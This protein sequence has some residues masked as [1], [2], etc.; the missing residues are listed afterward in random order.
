MR[1]IAD[2]IE[3]FIISE[4]FGDDTDSINVK[5]SQ[6][7]EKLSCAPSQITYTLTTRFTPEKGYEVESRRG[8]GGFI[9]IIRLHNVPRATLNSTTITNLTAGELVHA[10]EANSMLTDREAAVFNYFLNVFGD[11]VS[12]EDKLTMVKKAYSKMSGGK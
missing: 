2:D 12:E 5:R 3:K 6:L 4:L 11:Q 1:N 10:M 9:R 7:A 8:N